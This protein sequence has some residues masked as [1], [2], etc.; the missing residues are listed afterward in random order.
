VL[1]S[2]LTVVGILTVG[3][4][5]DE[6]S[7]HS[8]APKPRSTAP[9]NHTFRQPH[10]RG[11]AS[12]SVQFIA[13]N[14]SFGMGRGAARRWPRMA[15]R[16]PLRMARCRSSRSHSGQANKRPRAIRSLRCRDRGR[17]SCQSSIG[18]DARRS[19]RIACGG[20]AGRCT[21]TRGSLVCSTAAPAAS[22]LRRI[23]PRSGSQFSFQESGCEDI[24]DPFT[25]VRGIAPEFWAS[26]APLLRTA[27]EGGTAPRTLNPSL[28]F[29]RALGPFSQVCGIAP[30]FT[31]AGTVRLC[32]TGAN[33]SS[34]Q[35]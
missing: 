27:G 2:N 20:R 21:R 6:R 19:A 28:C 26:L 14:R 7:N 4:V 16:A 29:K 30:E 22:E 32:G 5:S 12:C 23:A 18:Y 9:V 35:S 13:R 33:T 8:S 17:P 31:A 11:A 10:P 34:R 24:Q 15:G 25:R 3:T 1:C